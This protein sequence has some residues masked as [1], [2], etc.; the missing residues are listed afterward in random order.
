MKMTSPRIAL[1]SGASTGLGKEL[2]PLISDLGFQIIKLG[3]KSAGIVDYRVDLT[4]PVLT[5]ELVN[6]I[7]DEHGPISLVIAN[8]GG[9]KKPAH[10]LSFE[11]LN[12]Y[13][14]DRNFSTAMNLITASMNSLLRTKGSVIAISSIVA[15]KEIENAPAGYAQS[16]KALN[17]YIREVASEQGKYGVRANLISPGNVYFPGSRWDELKTL[18]PELVSETLSKG[19]PLGNFIAPSEIAA[20]IEYLTSEGACNITGTNIVIDGGQSL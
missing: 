3:F 7:I 2:V 19:V 8:A 1:I 5:Q 14:M 6:R 9:G 10:E 18:N 4:D 17:A 13:F 12:A 15:I 16:K 11:E 20:A